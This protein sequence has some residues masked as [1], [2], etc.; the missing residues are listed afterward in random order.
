VKGAVWTCP[1]AGCGAAG[2]TKV[3]DAQAPLGIALDDTTVYWVDYDA[4]T[5]SRAPKVGGGSAFLYDGGSQALTSPGECAIDATFLYL[6]DAAADVYRVPLGGGEPILMANNGVLGAAPY[7]PIAL[8]ATNVYYGM[9]GAIMRLGKTA[10][11]GGTPFVSSVPNADGLAV[12]PSSGDLYWSDYGH[13]KDGAIGRMGTSGMTILASGLP[14]PTGLA[15]SG[16]YVL[17][18]SLGTPDG[19]GGFTPNSGAVTRILK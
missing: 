11:G 16:S 13:G 14:A 8:D 6:I 7:M 2:P 10:T 19:S 9:P 12:D 18:L 4:N 3:A 5:V 1:I 15:L 17:W